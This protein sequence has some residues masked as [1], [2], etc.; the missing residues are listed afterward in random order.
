MTIVFIT[1]MNMRQSYSLYSVF[2][3]G[4]M[5]ILDGGYV[6]IF[7]QLFILKKL[8]LKTLSETFEIINKYKGVNWELW[9]R[10]AG[11]LIL[12]LQY[13]AALISQLTTIQN[14]KSCMME[15][16]IVGRS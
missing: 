15:T 4:F 1:T 16:N 6:I 2:V 3:K 12:C 10:E 7:S 14:D 13:Q 9:K 11:F 5:L 8:N